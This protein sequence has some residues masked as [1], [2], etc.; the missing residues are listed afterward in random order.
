MPT[1]FSACLH[2]FSAGKNVQIAGN[3]VGH[4]YQPLIFMKERQAVMVNK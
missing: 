3:V 2:Q 1:V 4:Q